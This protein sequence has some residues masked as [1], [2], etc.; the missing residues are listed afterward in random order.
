MAIARAIVAGERSPQALLELCNA[1]I[2]SKKEQAVI[3]SLRGT[4]DDEH[5]FAL[6]QAIQSWEDYQQ[7]IADCDRRI[8]EILPT[9]NE[10]ATTS[11]NKAQTRRRQ[12]SRY[13]PSARNPDTNVRNRSHPP[14]CTDPLQR[15]PTDRRSR[16]RSKRLAD[17]EAL[18]RLGRIGAQK[19]RQRQTK[20]QH[21]NQMQPNRALV[22]YGRPELGEEQRYGTG[23]ILPTTQRT[24][25]WPGRHESCREKTR[26]LGLAP[27]G[28]R[29]R[30]RRKRAGTLCR[31]SSENQRSCPETTRQGARTTTRT[32]ELNT[33]SKKEVH[34]ERGSM[35][36]LLC[37]SGILSMGPRLREDDV[38]WE[39]GVAIPSQMSRRKKIP[40]NRGFFYFVDSAI[41]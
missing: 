28:K 20:G 22:L 15:A 26:H 24:W 9:R 27:D 33:T 39:L 31:T 10:Q 19:Q 13:R 17:G 37:R 2:R 1:Q 11:P 12:C 34:G 6:K 5:I 41:R 25:R 16:H 40:G 21:Q 18:R 8:A 3:E 38:L 14:A 23:W 35:L 7:L 32:D 36:S 4:W 30:I 29:R